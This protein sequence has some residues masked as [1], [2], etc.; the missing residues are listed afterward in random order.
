MGT[1]PTGDAKPRPK[2]STAADIGKLNLPPLAFAIEDLLA[3]GHAWGPPTRRVTAC[4]VIPDAEI[5]QITAAPGR[6]I[7][8]GRTS[9]HA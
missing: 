9:G 3:E 1:R 4:K 7:T 5:A 6:D 2:V 8:R